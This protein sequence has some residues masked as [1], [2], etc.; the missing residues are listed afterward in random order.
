MAGDELCEARRE[1]R[2]GSTPFILQVSMS[3]AAQCSPPPSE[4]AKRWFLRPSAIGRIERSTHRP[5]REGGAADPIG[6]GGAIERDAL[7]G[8]DSS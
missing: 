3:E 2:R 1:D 8:V 6:Q 4:P 7:A 5:Q